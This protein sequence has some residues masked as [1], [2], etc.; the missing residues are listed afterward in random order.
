MHTDISDIFEMASLSPFIIYV[1]I[2][3][4]MITRIKKNK[5]VTRTPQGRVTPPDNKA[6][7]YR[8]TAASAG[9]DSVKPVRKNNIGRS[10]NV[11]NIREPVRRNESVKQE[12]VMKDNTSSD[13]LAMQ[14]REER[15][16]MARISDMFQLKK[17]HMN[18]C[19]AE[20]I[21]RFHES[22]CDAGGIDD[23]VIN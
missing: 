8:N 10:A 3:I 19:D 9:K 5:N 23:G 15:R 12:S 14:L 22:S 2:I 16:A 1:I 11:Q 4:L 6:A 17:E 21:K 20:F 7:A 18:K 13:W